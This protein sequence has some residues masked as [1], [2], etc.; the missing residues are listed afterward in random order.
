MKLL[1]A[2]ASYGQ[3]NDKFL[4][5]VL[6]EY[7]SMPYHTD[8]VVF[9][10]IHKNLGADVEVIVG[11]PCKNPWSLPFAHK[12]LFAERQNAYDLFLYSEDDMLVTQNNIEAFLAASKVLPP[13]ELVGF[14]QY[15]QYPDGRRFFPAVHGHFHWIPESVKSVDG[16]RFARFT[17]EHSACYLMTRCQ[18]KE[19]IASG[20]FLVPPHEGKYDLLVTAGTD[21]YTQCGFTK[22]VCISHFEDFLVAHLPN[23]YAGTEL[24][25]DAPEFYRQIAALQ[26]VQQNGSAIKLLDA[27]TNVFHCRW[28][29]D[30]YESP[31]L[32]LLDCLPAQLSSLLSIGCGWG[33]TEAVL[34]NEGCRVVGIPLDSV[35]GICAESRGVETVYGD[36]EGALAQLSGERFDAVLMSGVLHLLPNPL[37]ALQLAGRLLSDD[38]LLIATVP[39]LNRLPDLWK[40]LRQPRRF[41]HLGDFERSGMHAFNRRSARRLF[42][43]SGLRIA[44][45]VE[46]VPEQWRDI[47]ALS[48]GIAA[49]LFSTEYIVVSL[50]TY[51]RKHGGS[52]TRLI[53]RET[54]RV[55][56]AR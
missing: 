48:G 12:T 15:E 22:L 42:T 55:P 21:P 11:L 7:R 1:V 3:K 5:R 36:L 8:V 2:I 44:D 37:K 29:K 30:Y 50:K 26:C 40:R 56:A 32:D 24:G 45:V 6:L 13:K 10:N 46:V 52:G 17:N 47:A 49:P 33:A 43:N 54:T 16:Y 34:V 35:I 41:R 53:E 20:G 27:E 31:R 23:R 14:F 38:G 18:L 28:S 19:A 51:P 4:E 9:S 39:N 25:Q